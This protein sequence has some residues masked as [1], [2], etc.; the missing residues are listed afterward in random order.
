MNYDIQKVKQAFS[1]NPELFIN[2]YFPNAKRK[3][4]NYHIGDVFGAEGESLVLG[5]KSYPGQFKDWATNDSGDFL[6]LL[7][8]NK[9]IYMLDALKEIAEL[10]SVRPEMDIAKA[11]VEIKP[12]KP[13]TKT[14][15]VEESSP[16]AKYLSDERGINLETQEA[17]RIETTSKNSIAYP[18]IN[19]KGEIIQRHYVGLERDEKGKKKCG[20][21]KGA[22]HYCFGMHLLDP[23]TRSLILTEGQID[24]MTAY[25][26]GIKNVLSIPM[27][28]GKFDFIDIHWELFTQ[29][30]DIVICFDMDDK[31]QSFAED[32]AK[33]LGIDRCRIAELDE[34]DL[35]DC[36]NNGDDEEDLRNYIK[37]A[38]HLDNERVYELGKSES[39]IL[40]YIKQ[41]EENAG[42]PFF[43]PELEF[44]H[45]MG[46][47]TI[48]TGYSGSGK[49]T[50]LNQNILGLMEQ[51]SEYRAFY[52]SFEQNTHDLEIL[53]LKQMAGSQYKERI[54][55]Y[56]PFIR[57]RVYDYIPSE[58]A[59]IS[60]LFETMLYALN[61]YGCKIFV[62]DNL[63]T[64]GIAE[65][66]EVAIQAFVKKLSDFADKNL[67]H[68]HLVAH[69]RKSDKDDNESKV[70]SKHTVRGTSSITDIA[71]NGVTVWRNPG[72]DSSG[73]DEDGVIKVWKQRETGVMNTVRYYFNNAFKCATTKQ[74]KT[75][76]PIQL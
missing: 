72:S 11:R 6:D 49:T 71:D 50:I 2:H 32:V 40:D 69:S 54:D 64:C 36:W 23:N 45:R 28:V 8:T 75:I 46:E 41:K 74:C 33:R 48:W 1:G 10:Y 44:K 53:F 61:R 55:A 51:N 20:Q 65:G 67:V 27:G 52:A 19:P 76:E 16:A 59:T 42:E 43:L 26:A 30:D 4:G 17:F 60:E 39:R 66:D 70:P 56:L 15:K 63:V 18:H 37:K 5:V 34:N 29:C 47:L 31:G 24:C 13:I 25:Q 7:G 38:K 57:G 21:D 12:L 73:V 58:S 62:I 35:N 68:V 3:S 14:V 9:G 22:I